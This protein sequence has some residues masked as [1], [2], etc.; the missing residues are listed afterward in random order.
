MISQFGFS[1]ARE[2]PATVLQ[3]LATGAYTLH[4]GVVRQATG[5]IVRHLV[6]PGLVGSVVSSPIGFLAAAG[7]MASGLAA[8]VQIHALSQD[9]RRVL[10]VSMAATGLAGLGLATSLIGFPYL[11]ARIKRVDQKVDKLTELIKSREGA[12]LRQAVD[13][14]RQSAEASEATRKSML[15][16]AQGS[17]GELAHHYKSQLG[18]L[19]K[20]ADIEGAE[21]YFVVACLGNAICSSELGLTGSA[22][23][24][25]TS[26]YRDWAELSRRH[27][28][29]L[30]KLSEPARLLDARYIEALPAATL[31]KL[32]DFA[33]QD[34]RGMAWFDELRRALGTGTMIAGT[35]SRIDSAAI[36][37]AKS[38]QARDEVL[39]S[40]VSL[41][42]LLA[43]KKLSVTAFAQA[44]EKERA[45]SGADLVWV[46]ESR[47]V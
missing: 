23:D 45:D 21:G 37:Y 39:E 18:T 19:T 29:S 41:F 6:S 34:P 25:L 30:L 8:N 28:S 36:E 46:S 14:Y 17:F 2:I 9:V 7:S 11:A 13:D 5:Q 32:L 3:G 24:Q 26:H 15:L 12:Q 38:L 47:S 42:D 40:F 27:C 22:S 16:R 44:V 1:V 35:V 20:L 31:V 4:G 10:N 33:N 43:T